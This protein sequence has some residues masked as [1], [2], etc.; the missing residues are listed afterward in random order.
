M[1]KKF[2]LA[3]TV[4]AA[5]GAQSAAAENVMI[6]GNVAAKCI[7]HTDTPGVYGNPSHSVLS[8]ARTDGGIQPII[9]YD[10]VQ[11]G[12]YKAAITTPSSFSSSPVLS[13]VVTWTGSVEVSQVSDAAMS[14]YTTNKRI[15]N[16]TTEFD[17]T[18]TGTTWF[19]ASS[20]AVYGVDKA[21]PGGEYKAIVIAECIAL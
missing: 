19:K 4:L 1:L 2:L 10:V 21:F 18:V 8:T 12:Y 3:A 11:G 14:A 6:T 7:I 13:D 9:R 17:L 5:V 15:Y 20:K 16:N